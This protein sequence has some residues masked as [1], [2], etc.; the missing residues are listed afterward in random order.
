MVS[1]EEIRKYCKEKY[2]FNAR[3]T[4]ISHAKEIS[5]LPTR[6]AP[7]RKNVE[8][9]WPCPKKRLPQIKEAFIHSGMLKE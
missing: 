4:W 9:A 7:N 3:N 6:K 8:R 5:G 2:G 1:N